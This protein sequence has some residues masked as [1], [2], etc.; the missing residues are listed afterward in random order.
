MSGGN[1]QVVIE[2]CTKLGFTPLLGA[3]RYNNPECVA[4]LL[5]KGANILASN[6]PE[7]ARVLSALLWAVV[8]HSPSIVKVSPLGIYT[9]STCEL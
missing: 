3:V 2:K 9:S 1:V 4:V 8:V 5:S 7:N 6:R